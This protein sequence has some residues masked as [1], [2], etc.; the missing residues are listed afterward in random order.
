MPTTRV[1]SNFL[2]EPCPHCGAQTLVAAYRSHTRE[3][4][5]CGTCERGSNVPRC[6]ERERPSVVPHAGT[7]LDRCP[8]C[9][10]EQATLTLV[11]GSLQ[12]WRCNACGHA[13]TSPVAQAALKALAADDTETDE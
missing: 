8:R 6:F 12:W 9:R 1:D 3:Y 5:F 7:D 2:D 11:T 4:R 13:W 10:G